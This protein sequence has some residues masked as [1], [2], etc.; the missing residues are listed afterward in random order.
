MKSETTEA[1]GILLTAF[2]GFTLAKPGTLLNAGRHFTEGIF[3]SS[4]CEQIH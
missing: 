1:V 3:V 2:V 4:S